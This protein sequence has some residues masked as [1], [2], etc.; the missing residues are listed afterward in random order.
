[1]SVHRTHQTWSPVD[2]EHSSAWPSCWVVMWRPSLSINITLHNAP[3]LWYAV[4]VHPTKEWT[5]LSLSFIHWLGMICKSPLQG[6]RINLRVALPYL[7]WEW[8]PTRK[9]KRD[10]EHPTYTHAYLN[11]YGI[12][13]WYVAT[14]HLLVT[15]Q[16]Y[17]LTKN[18]L[19][20]ESAGQLYSPFPDNVPHW[21]IA[22]LAARIIIGGTIYEYLQL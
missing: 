12:E 19:H 10:V 13:R 1:M 21:S 5:S 22:A 20:L 4:F 3:C 2:Q 7:I 17:P 14:I 11:D 9:M 6:L 16:R 18:G 8:R 15:R